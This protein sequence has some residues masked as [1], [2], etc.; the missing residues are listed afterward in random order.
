MRFF[1]AWLALL[2]LLL[3]GSTALAQTLGPS[4][5][6]LPRYASVKGS[7]VNVRTGPGMGF[8]IRWVITLKGVPLRIVEES[9]DWRRVEDVEGELGWVHVSLLSGKRSALVTGAKTQALHR[10]PTPEARIVLLAEPGAF[11]WLKTC[12]ADWCRLAFDGTEG[13]MRRAALWGAEER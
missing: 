10:R 9:G 11:G 8:P 7:T 2:P 6:P 3:V 5:N 13:W 4:G 12:E 1:L